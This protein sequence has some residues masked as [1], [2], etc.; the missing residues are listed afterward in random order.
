MEI[1]KFLQNMKL[2]VLKNNLKVMQNQCASEMYRRFKICG[3]PG[4]D[5]YEGQVDAYKHAIDLIDKMM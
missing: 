4:Y 3:R 1:R 2:L 5:Y